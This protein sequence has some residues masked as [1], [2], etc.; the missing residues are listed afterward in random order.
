MKNKNL[1]E[2]SLPEYLFSI[3]ITLSFTVPAYMEQSPSCKA[4]THLL[5]KF[6]TIYGTQRFI[7]IFTKAITGPCPES[8]ESSPNCHIPC[9]YNLF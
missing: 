3:Y 5:Q 1:T 2:E 4:N 7:T 9:P 8:D 6:L